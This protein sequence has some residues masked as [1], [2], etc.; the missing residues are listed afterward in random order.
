[1]RLQGDIDD[2]REEPAGVRLAAGLVVERSG[3][4]VAVDQTLAGEVGVFQTFGGFDQLEADGVLEGDDVAVVDHQAFAFFQ[5]VLDEG[6]A[7][8]AEDGAL[9]GGVQEEKALLGHD[10]FQAAVAHLDVG[11]RGAG[12]VAA[13]GEVVAAGPF[14]GGAF[15]GGFLGID[16]KFQDVAQV[17]RGEHEGLVVAVA[18]VNVGEVLFAREHALEAREHAALAAE[19]AGFDGDVDAGGHAEHGAGL[20]AHLLARVEGE[21][22]HREGGAVADIPVH[23][24]GR[25]GGFQTRPRG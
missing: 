9:A 13:A 5:R 2:A 23:A 3:A 22:D 11:A 1:M 12:E 21:V 17:G 15:G 7:G 18:D 4:G 19:A 20:G 10:A 14:A 24:M 8:G 25:R 6:A 16:F